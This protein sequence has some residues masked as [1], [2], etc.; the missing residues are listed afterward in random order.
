MVVLEEVEVHLDVGL[1]GDRFKGRP[2][3]ARQ[4]T[5]IQREHLSVIASVLDRA[6]IDPSLLRR[7]IVVSAINLL[8]LKDKHFRIGGVLAIYAAAKDFTIE[9]YLKA[10]L[11]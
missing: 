2:G 7:N 4:V 11:E 1:V 8:A 9:K 10:G 5:L 3:S 6:D